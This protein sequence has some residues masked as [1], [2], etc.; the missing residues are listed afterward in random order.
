MVENRIRAVLKKAA[1]DLKDS[2]SPSAILDAELLLLHVYSLHGRVLNK[3]S[4][5]T[6]CED[7]VPK[8]MIAEYEGLV[9]QRCQG[10]PVQY[11]TG[12]Q[13]FMG[14]ELAVAEGVLIPRGDTEIIVEKVLE[15]A[16]QEEALHII[17]MCTGTGAIAVS[18]AHFLP[19]AVITVADISDTALQCCRTNIRKHHLQDRVKAIKSNLFE[20][21]TRIDFTNNIDMIVSNPPYI[22]RADIAALDVNVRDY[23]PALALDG[24][25]DGLDFYRRIAHEGAELLKSGGILA[26]EIGYNQ[27]QDVLNIIKESQSYYDLE[28]FQDLAGLDR[29]IIA[30]KR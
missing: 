12:V 25:L 11:I 18:L 14:L 22:P 7:E 29:C 26:F 2:G 3:I 10:K 9:A 13:E 19:R 1:R 20:D 15:L 23:E 16:D 5:I 17:D 30:R 4:L 28:C 6:N 24:G 8:A 27:G 21:L